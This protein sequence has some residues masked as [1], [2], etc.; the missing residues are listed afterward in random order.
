MTRGATTKKGTKAKSNGK[1]TVHVAL[2]EDLKGKLDKMA[3]TDHR[4]HGDFVRFLID[5][6]WERRQGVAS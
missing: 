1:P 6:E 2:T 4:K 5:R 3:L